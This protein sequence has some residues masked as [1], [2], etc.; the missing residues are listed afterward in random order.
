MKVVVLISCMHQIDFSII[1]KMNLQTDAVII[2]QCDKETVE[3]SDFLNK[4]NEL[5]HVKM[6]STTERGLSRSRNMAIQN[7]WGDICLICDDDEILSDNY[8]DTIL[9]AYLSNNNVECITFHVE[10]KDRSFSAKSLGNQRSVGFRGIMQTSSVQITFLRNAIIDNDIKF[11]I[12]LGSG[13]GNGS[14]EENKFLLD[15]KR[16]GI[17]ILYVPQTIATVLPGTSLWFKGFNE[18]Y[19]RN[20]GWSSRRSLGCFIGFLYIIYFWIK[21]VNIYKSEI[22]PYNALVC[23]IKGYFENRQ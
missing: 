13:T 1:E 9:A 12:L 8:E 5:C 2:N 7:A 18:T 17:K 20:Q 21:H 6:I 4:K 14:G 15:I 3:E 10:R 22:S 16:K 11:D 23:L 19:M